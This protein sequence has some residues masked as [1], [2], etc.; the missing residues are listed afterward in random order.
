MK[1]SYRSA[2]SVIFLLQ[3]LLLPALA[4]A[5]VLTPRELAGKLATALSG[6]AGGGAQGSVAVLD[7]PYY[8]GKLGLGS[9]KAAD[10]LAV[11]LA[12]AGVKV[13]ER[14]LLEQLLREKKLE[15]S[16]L[17][18]ESTVA[19][20]GRLSG[21]AFF[22]LGT[23]EDREDGVSSLNLRLVDAGTGLMIHGGEYLLARDWERRAV[24]RDFDGKLE[25][26]V[27][28]E[29]E[30]K[31]MP[32]LSPSRP[33]SGLLDLS[34]VDIAALEKYDALLR[35]EKSSPDYSGI[36]AGWEEFASVAPKHKEISL[37]RAESWRRYADELLRRETRAALREGE[38]EE[39]FAKLSRL[40]ALETIAHA[41]KAAFAEKFLDAYGWDSPHAA[42]V[43]IYLPVPCVQGKKAGFCYPD[44]SVA[45][46]GRYDMVMTFREGLALVQTGNK[47]GYV[48][49]AGT[50]VIK[51]ASFE[52]AGAFS[53]GLAPVR[54]KKWG[55]IDR[56]GK[57]V[58]KPVYYEGGLF[59]EGRAAVRIE[60]KWGYIDTSGKLVIPVKYD[61]AG[62]F[63]EGSAIVK[64]GRKYGL[65]D[66]EG[67]YLAE[68]GYNVIHPFSGGL[69]RVAVGEK[70]GYIDRRGRIVLEPVYDHAG[71]LSGGLARVAV[72]KKF[73]YI[74]R[75]G[76]IVLEP[77]YDHAGDFSEGLA[78]FCKDRKCGFIDKSG[79][80]VPG[81]EFPSNRGEGYSFRREHDLSKIR[82][83]EGLAAVPRTTDSGLFFKYVYIDRR[84]EV[85][86]PGEYK[87]AAPFEGGAAIVEKEVDGFAIGSL[88]KVKQ[89]AVI[90]RK[91]KGKLIDGCYS[92]KRVGAEIFVAK[93]NPSCILG[94][95]GWKQ[96]GHSEF[97]DMQG[98]FA[99]VKGYYGTYLLDNWGHSM[100]VPK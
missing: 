15:R 24:P 25:M 100:P 56:R 8:D 78:S 93:E 70:F 48:D 66:P 58:I 53:E 41:Q 28:F 52:R 17:F 35:L 32:A 96:C 46:A 95:R 50:Q 88:A 2:L 31:G 91:G 82:F 21:A 97:L 74:D 9:V 84:G 27:S 98:E 38:M 94:A 63:K 12:G 67:K 30:Q 13:A 22:V 5:G 86:F 49:L 23:L 69:A 40:F 10:A 3:A 18:D 26:S 60:G 57:V 99:R 62:G 73:G 6:A 83:S 20:L 16:G 64:A 79:E 45:I 29:P 89:C 85:A 39:A 14:R 44:G 51:P 7:F 59:S 36:A 42:A 80:P 75:S 34:G 55:Y 33:A 81:L 71:E 47:R 77:V 1:I 76:H 19:E 4:G 61:S 11:N 54:I 68:P 92:I 65:I 90:D 43:R 37:A 87:E 72:G